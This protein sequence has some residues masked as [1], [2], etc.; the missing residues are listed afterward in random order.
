MKTNKIEQLEA[1][2]KAKNLTIKLLTNNIKKERA[3]I[4]KIYKDYLVDLE[5]YD[6]YV[7]EYGT[8]GQKVINVIKNLDIDSIDFNAGFEQGYLFALQAVL[9]LK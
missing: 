8:K 4:E 2:N 9:E 3:R 7:D 1:G 5:T 6:Q